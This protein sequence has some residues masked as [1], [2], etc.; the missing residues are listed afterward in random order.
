M[1]SKKLTF[2]VFDN[3]KPFHIQKGTDIGGKSHWSLIADGNEVFEIDLPKHF[4]IDQAARL[5]IGA[6]RAEQAI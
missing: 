1:T 6:A 3:G 5:A 2:P 4:S